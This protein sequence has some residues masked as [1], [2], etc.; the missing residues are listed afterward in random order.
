[1]APRELSEMI[2]MGFLEGKFTKRLVKGALSFF[3]YTL[4]G[5]KHMFTSQ[6]AL[7]SQ[8]WLLLK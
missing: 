8:D 1:M 5:S 2:F 7:E 4:D 3:M 6:M